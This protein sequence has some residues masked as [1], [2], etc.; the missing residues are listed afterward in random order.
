M[1]GAIEVDSKVGS[2]T[3]FKI[4]LPASMI[5]FR[6]NV[7][8]PSQPSHDQGSEARAPLRLRV[9]LVEDHDTTREGT[10]DILAA[11]GVTVME[12][13]CARE[14]LSA[15][16]EHEVDVL[17]LDMMLPD[18]DGREVLREI[19]KRPRKLKGILVLT[20]DLTPERLEEIKRLGAD[21]VIEKPADM[22]KLLRA[23]RSYDGRAPAC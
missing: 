21:G 11:E 23:L 7:A 14:A 12:A 1:G 9:L 2:G 22:S 8:A 6:I 3:E 18:M 19:E 10:K 15:L 13:S 4:C 20:G 17:L 16:A 5:V